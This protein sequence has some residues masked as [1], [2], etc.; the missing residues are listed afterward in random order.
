MQMVE[1]KL[2]ITIHI[3]PHLKNTVDRSVD[4]LLISKK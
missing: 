4:D 1:V 3:T 2:N